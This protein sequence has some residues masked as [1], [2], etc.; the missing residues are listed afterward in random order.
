MTI[1]Y[2][3]VGEWGMIESSECGVP[4]AAGK[5]RAECGVRSSECPPRRVN[6]IR[7]AEFSLAR[8]LPE[9]EEIL[10]EDFDG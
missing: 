7:N 5:L 10:S 4:A 1:A 3:G 2:T 9:D 8:P 6:S